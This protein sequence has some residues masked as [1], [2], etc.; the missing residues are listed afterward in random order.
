MDAKWNLNI[1]KQLRLLLMTREV[2]QCQTASKCPALGHRALP[3]G[4][5]YCWPLHCRAWGTGLSIAG[6]QHRRG[7][8]VLQMVGPSSARDLQKVLL[9][10]VSPQ[11]CSPAY[12]STD[13][14]WT[15][16]STEERVKHPSPWHQDTA[17]SN[18]GNLC[19]A[20]SDPA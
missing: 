2:L 20:L 7:Q 15:Q 1:H 9:G 8:S 17:S 4:R 14:I 19:L 18:H 3:P 13:L 16:D 6:C 10:Q 11:L 5:P 12:M